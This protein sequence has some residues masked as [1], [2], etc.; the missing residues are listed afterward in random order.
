MECSCVVVVVV[1]SFRREGLFGNLVDKRTGLE[2]LVLKE[3]LTDLNGTFR[4]ISSERQFADS[5]TK[6]AT[7]QLLADRLRYGRIK[8]T[9]DAEYTAAKRK[10]AEDRQMSR[11]EFIQTKETTENMDTEDEKPTEGHAFSLSTNYI[12]L[13]QTIMMNEF[14]PEEMALVENTDEVLTETNVVLEKD[15]SKERFPVIVDFVVAL[16]RAMLMVY[17]LTIPRT[18]AAADVEIYAPSYDW[19]QPAIN[20][21]LL[22]SCIALGTYLIGGWIGWARCRQYV[23]NQACPI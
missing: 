9:Y 22:L 12:D 16:F 14:C 20:L 1:G 2:I 21:A 7:R 23:L 19:L 6:T 17:V 18:V 8:F 10:T 15:A 13:V 5:L 3:R 11:N 4:W